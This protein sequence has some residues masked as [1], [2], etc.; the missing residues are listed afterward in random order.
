MA[1]AD[2]FVF[3]NDELLSEDDMVLLKG[4]FTYPYHRRL[5]NLYLQLVLCG[6]DHLSKSKLGSSSI[7]DALDCLATLESLKA[8]SLIYDIQDGGDAERDRFFESAFH[9]VT[10]LCCLESFM[11]LREGIDFKG[12]DYEMSPRL[13]LAHPSLSLKTLSVGLDPPQAHI[14][15]W[16]TTPRAGYQL[17]HMTV[18]PVNRS[19][20]SELSAIRPCIPL[21]KSL[22]INAPPFLSTEHNEDNENSK[23]RLM[24][25]EIMCEALSVETLTLRF[26]FDYRSNDFKTITV[27]SL[28]P[29][30]QRLSLLF[31]T[32]ISLEEAEQNNYTVQLDDVV[33]Q[34]ALSLNLKGSLRV[35][36]FNGRR[37]VNLSYTSGETLTIETAAKKTCGKSVKNHFL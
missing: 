6:S 14:F 36:V 4:I 8:L 18:F 5:R 9:V 31:S 29:A 24:F 15:S 25:T 17:D 13:A 35:I 26:H 1:F 21:L 37:Y 30:L 2:T 10:R 20:E 33:S 11:M 32:R 34:I 3:E 19:H 7:A 23:A 28:P 27:S 22:S 12:T 16:L